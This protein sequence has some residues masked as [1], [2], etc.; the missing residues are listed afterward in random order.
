[1]S[2]IK[3]AILIFCLLS[4][5][6]NIKG[7]VKGFQQTEIF[8]NNSA[9]DQK[10]ALNH[11]NSNDFDVYNLVENNVVQNS[12]TVADTIVKQ[13]VI[14]DTFSFRYK[15]KK[16]DTL[17]YSV[18]SRDSIT[19]NYGAPLLRLRHEKIMIT[20]D[21]VTPE[22]NFRLTQ[23]LVSFESRESFLNE[24]NVPRNSTTWLNV[25]VHLEIDSLGRR[26]KAYNPDS[27]MGGL[28]P[29]GAF[30]PF[31]IL[32]LLDSGENENKKLTNESW[33]FTRT[34]DIPENGIPVPLLR[35]SLLYRMIGIHDTLDF[36]SA[37]KMTFIMTSQGSI[38]V[39][40]DDMAFTTFSINNAGGE[41]FWDTTNWIPVFYYHTVEQRLTIQHSDKSKADPGFHYIFST[42]VLDEFR[43]RK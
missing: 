40:D 29:G 5:N 32:P 18:F 20:C 36:K 30:Q 6:F 35:Y 14:R 2:Y 16:G 37:L 24:K 41:I 22:G 10:I 7:N 3:I 15:F 12:S 1:M 17:V 26:Q 13:E 31:I 19:I 23:Q 42:F 9:A 27:L 21:S 11:S 38:V 33:M 43:R 8:L 25:P 39:N 34:D 4:A 28:T